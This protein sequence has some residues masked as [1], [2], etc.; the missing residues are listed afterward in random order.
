MPDSARVSPQRLP[1]LSRVCD[2]LLAGERNL[3]ARRDLADRLE[4]RFPGTVRA[5]V[6]ARALTGRGVIWCARQGDDPRG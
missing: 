3:S 6:E 1:S 4:L 5:A 2:A